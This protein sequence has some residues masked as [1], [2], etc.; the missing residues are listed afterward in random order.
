MSIKGSVSN[1]RPSVAGMTPL[2]QAAASSN[3]RL[4]Q[5][6]LSAM[7]IVQDSVE[8]V[9]GTKNLR[10][11]GGIDDKDGEGR[12]ALL[13]AVHSNSL[14]CVRVLVEQGANINMERSGKAYTL[15]VDTIETST[16][17]YRVHCL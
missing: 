13:H 8:K 16:N 6:I 15:N 12:T 1:T 17:Y 11:R 9:L 2:H 4:M 7:P 5:D 10:K 3:L 14:K